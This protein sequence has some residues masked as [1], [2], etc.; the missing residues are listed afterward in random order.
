MTHE[1]NN[2]WDEWRNHILI[3][4]KEL[5]EAEKITQ[6]AV[7]EVRTEVALLKLKASLWGGFAG[8]GMYVATMALEIFKRRP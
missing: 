1:E 2:G 8:L 3:E 7:A 5:K 4:L 6:E